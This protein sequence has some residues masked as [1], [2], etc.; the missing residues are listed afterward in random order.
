[1]LDIS[2]WAVAFRLVWLSR[3]VGQGTDE[4][5]AKAEVGVRKWGSYP[6]ARD[7]VH[8][9][10]HEPVWAVWVTMRAI[11]KIINPELIKV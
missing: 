6:R 5:I 9:A 10:R 2:G 1:M 3:D 8:N 11:H 7:M 4:E